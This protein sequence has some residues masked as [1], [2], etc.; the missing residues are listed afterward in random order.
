VVIE[1][2]RETEREWI[3]R[4]RGLLVFVWGEEYKSWDISVST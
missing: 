1:L 2:E 4:E 3:N